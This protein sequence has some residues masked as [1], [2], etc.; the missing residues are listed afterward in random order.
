MGKPA[1]RLGDLTQHGGTVMLGN[2]TIMMGKMPASTLGDMHVCPMCTGPVPHVG[3]PI[4]LGSMGVMVGK[5][6]SARISDMA[7]CVGP[8]SMNALGC[9]TVMIGE[10]GSGSSAASAGSA[11]EAQAAKKK[12]PK[13]IGAFPLG[14]PP[15]PT[16]SHEIKV[17]FT[18]SAGKPL[19]GVRYAIKDPDKQELIGAST[20][21]GAAVHGGYAKKGSYEL[22]VPELNKAK[23]KKPSVKMGEEAEFSVAA[24]MAETAKDA[25]VIIFENRGPK[26]RVV[27]NLA[28]AVQGKKVEGKWKP[29]YQDLESPS[30]NPVVAG[31]EPAPPAEKPTYDFIC[32]VDGLVAV[33][34]LLKIADTLEIELLDAD[35][36]GIADHEY[37][38]TLPGGEIRKGKLDGSGKATFEDLEPGGAEVRFPGMLG[39]GEPEHV[40]EMDEVVITANGDQGDGTAR[41]KN[42]SS[43]ESSSTDN[44]EEEMDT[45]KLD[46]LMAKKSLDTEEIIEARSLIMELPSSKKPEY[47][48]RLQAKTKYRSQ[49]DNNQK[50][51]VSD[52]M[53]N[54]TSLAMALEYLGVKNPD[55]QMQFEDYLEKVRE[56][57]KFPARTDSESWDKLAEVF[58]VKSKKIGLWTSDK[59]ILRKNLKPEIENGH[60]VVI[61]IFSVKSGKGHI[62]RLQ[63]IEDDG[64]VVDDPFGKLNDFKQ[65]EQGGSG[66]TGTANSRNAG[67]NMGEDNLWNWASIEMTQ[68]KYAD[69]FYNGK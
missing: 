21:D 65:R 54:L 64:L 61:S 48:I 15:G 68:I 69:I 27:A 11:A 3:G 44:F 10:V 35:G 50:H 47:Y 43:G 7:V 59:K 57:K 12:G 45:E 29:V 46:K 1:A 25:Q 8:P 67:S 53:C 23:W 66:Y 42:Q 6:P 4:T 37:E 14:E 56:E 33:S 30:H 34:D 31:V 55:P 22:F 52:R 13:A 5:K 62:V 63:S 40:I 32:V 39:S 58:E 17:E 24:D 41:G 49:R 20:M 18:D 28:L 51:N 19:S 16:E 26:R 9:F 60:G 2:P 38:L 36:K